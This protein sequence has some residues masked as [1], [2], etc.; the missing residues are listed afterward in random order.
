MKHIFIL[1]LLCLSTSLASAQTQITVNFN[2]EITKVNPRNFGVNVQR[3]F[4]PDIA[5]DSSFKAKLKELDPSI[6]RYHAFEQIL[7]GH[8]NN[9]IDYENRRWDKAKI[10]NVLSH[11]KSDAAILITIT[12]WPSWMNDSSN[13]KKLD[14][15]KVEEYADFTADLVD[16]VRN[17]LGHKVEFWEPFNEKDGG[18]GKYD[19]EKDMIELAEIHKRCAE[20]MKNKRSDIKIVAGVFRQPYTPNIN[21][22]LKALAGSN[23]F[24]VFSYHHYPSGGITSIPEIFNMADDFIIGANSVR[25]KLNGNGFTDIPMWLDE[26]NLFWSYDALGYENMT[27]AVGGVFDALALKSIM[28]SGKIDAAMT[29]NAGDGRYGKIRSDFSD[30]TNGGYVY[31]TLKTLAQGS[32]C[33]TSSTDNQNVVGF[34]TARTDGEYMFMIVNR[35]NKSTYSR[36]TAPNWK[37]NDKTLQVTRINEDGLSNG[38]MNWDS[39][40][41]V[42]GIQL[43]KHEIAFFVTQG[44]GT[45][46][47]PSLDLNGKIITLQSSNNL[48]VSS[49][50]GLEAMN[51]DRGNASEWEQFT[52][53]DDNDDGIVA[54]KGSNNKYVSSEN[55]EKPIYCN[56]G[57]INSYEE[58]VWIDLGDGKIALQGN[59]NRYVSSENGLQPM[60]C[61]RETIGEWEIFEYSIVGNKNFEGLSEN[62]LN[63]YPNPTRDGIFNLSLSNISKE[64]VKIFD[65]SGRAIGYTF[66]SENKN[67]L[68]I[69]I[70]VTTGIYIVQAGNIKNKSII[71]AKLIVK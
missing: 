64:N 9:W 38:T 70:E 21:F 8:S 5:S 63:L 69:K 50:D 25:A 68:Q 55:G 24:D 3:A 15:A 32:V 13:P 17:Q 6:I 27:N 7:N 52:I 49:E 12:G 43:Q 20:K 62:I 71:Q 35:S 60:T 4:N 65:L 40:N 23:S 58:F 16:I 10:D 1:L 46:D 53:I 44:G 30:L 47:I 19:G 59:N 42:T 39:L 36:I 22:F 31:K 28:E 56:R 61:N 11:K 45:I 18:N 33:R 37:P 14:P 48:F 57:K 67:L 34:A 51:A 2:N 41:N 26:Y 66:V 54:L 29:W